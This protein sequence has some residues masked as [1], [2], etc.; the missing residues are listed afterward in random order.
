VPLKPANLDW[1]TEVPLHWKHTRLKNVAQVQTGI[2]LGKDYGQ[3]PKHPYPYLRVANVQ[4]GRLDL[5]AV[6]IVDIPEAEASGCML[7]AGDVLMTEGGDIDKLGRGCVWRNEIPDC[8]HQNHVFAVRCHRTLIPEFLAALMSSAQGRAYF[9][10]TAKQTTNLASTNSSTLRAFPFFLPEFD[11]Q[12]AILKWASDQTRELA[13]AIDRAEREIEL[14]REYRTRLTADV[15]T[16]KLDVRHLAPPP[17]SF[18]SVELAGIEA[19]E[20]LDD[21]SVEEDAELVEN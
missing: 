2:T 1:F 13:A 18:E 12:A 3:K 5:R 8:V 17:G 20:S 6:K 7:Q 11:E 4:A 14:I 15:V 16:G 9:Q 10:S 19:D 21:G